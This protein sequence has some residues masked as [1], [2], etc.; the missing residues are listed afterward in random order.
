MDREVILVAVDASKE[1]TDYALEWAVCN[2]IKAMDCLV[3]VAILPSL[4]PPHPAASGPGNQIHQ[5]VSSLLKKRGLLAHNDQNSCDNTSFVDGHDVAQRINYV[6]LEMMQQLFSLHNVVQVITQVR[7]EADA[8]MGS[9]AMVAKELGATWVI[10]DR[11]LKKEGDCCVTLLNS[12]IILV[13]HAIPKILRRPVD[14]LTGK[15]LDLSDPTMADMLGL[16]PTCSMVKDQFHKASHPVTKFKP[17]SPHLSSHELE[18]EAINSSASCCKSQSSYKTAKFDI[19]SPHKSTASSIEE[20]TKSC[21]AT[22]SGKSKRDIN[23]NNGVNAMQT[24]A[25]PPRRSTNSP[26]LLQKPRS[27]NQSRQSIISN[28]KNAAV[29]CPSSSTIERTSSIRRIMSLSIKQPP[30][31]PPLCSVCKHNA[32]ILGKA[33]QRFGYKEIENATDG[34]SRDNFLAEGGSGLVYRGVLPDGQV[35]AVKRHKMLSAQGASEFC[36]EVEVLS[37]AQ[38]RNLVMLVGYC[39]EIEWLLVYEFACNGSLDKHLYGTETNKVMGWHNRMK[40]AMGAARGLR[41]LHEDCR[42]GCIVHRDFRP[43]NI[44]LTHDFEPMVGD[45]GLARWQTDGQSAEETCIIGA[46]GYLAPEYTQTGLIT[47]K[48]DVY[49][50]GVVLLELLTGIT[51]TEFSKIGGRQ[52]LAEWAS[53]LLPSRLSVE[54]KIFNGIIDP[55]LENNYVD[56]EV[57]CMMYA[58]ILC[59]SPY[60]ERRP[61]MSKILKILEGDMLS[62]MAC[63]RGQSIPDYPKQNLNWNTADRPWNQKLYVSPSSHLMQTIHNMNLSPS[64]HGARGNN[65]WNSI[66]KPKTPSNEYKMASGDWDL[67]Q[68]EL[69]INEEYRE[70]LQ[71]SLSK[72]INNLIVK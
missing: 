47:E 6:C 58:A 66:F 39:T 65:D 24:A 15:K 61:R 34:F 13:D 62:Y 40:V 2:V 35:V 72:F 52:Y 46:F 11:R 21:S 8:Q 20:K 48:A 51:A 43:T 1:I 9:V 60:P 45:F 71:G 23:R 55:R 59:T 53:V 12:N 56:K 32:P 19:E 41:Y 31:P 37:C 67:N 17:T 69:S 33:P 14:F 25:T 4:Q 63:G 54:R 64:K 36:C 42:V 16:L 26:H 70:Y 57:E 50:F 28:N 22:T 29:V 5:F 30:T 7:V 10:L 68:S 3:L 44:L 27:P 38:H 18:T 49:A